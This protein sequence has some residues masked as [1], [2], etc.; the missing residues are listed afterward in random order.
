MIRR[1]RSHHAP[2]ETSTLWIRRRRDLAIETDYESLQVLHSPQGTVRAPHAVSDPRGSTSCNLLAWGPPSCWKTCG[3]A[4][5]SKTPG[6][7]QAVRRQD[8]GPAAATVCTVL[9]AAAGIVECCPSRKASHV[10]DWPQPSQKEGRRMGDVPQV[11]LSH[12]PSASCY[13]ALSLCAHT[14]AGTC[15]KPARPSS[16]LKPRVL[17]RTAEGTCEVT[18]PDQGTLCFSRYTKNMTY[19]TVQYQQVR[20]PTIIQT[21]KLCGPIRSPL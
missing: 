16:L 17:E 6:G 9:Y 8:E 3:A 13:G 14:T 4:T 12:E 7:G 5:A 10:G 1:P 18:L 21:A 15:K 11:P 2:D 20:L 19:S